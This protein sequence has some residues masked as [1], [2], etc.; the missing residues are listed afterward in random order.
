MNEKCSMVLPWPLPFQGTLR[1]QRFSQ[2]KWRSDSPRIRQ[3]AITI[4]R[5]FALFLRSTGESL[6][7]RLNA[8]KLRSPMNWAFRSALSQAYLEHYTRSMSADKHTLL[9]IEEPKRLSNSKRFSI[10]V[11]SWSV[12]PSVRWHSCSWGE[13]TRYRDIPPRQKVHIT[14]SS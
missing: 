2:K 3:C 9:R 10:I 7:P 14:I 5:R 13:H 6:R 8:S 4:F 11:E 1:V 12:M